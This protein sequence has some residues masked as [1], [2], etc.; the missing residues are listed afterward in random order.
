MLLIM[1]IYTILSG[2]YP[3]IWVLVPSLIIKNASLWS[4][5]Q[6]SMVIMVVGLLA[7]ICGFMTSF[8]KGNYRM[9][10]NN[11][12][13]YLIRD[14]M[15]SSLTMPYEETLHPDTLDRINFANESVQNPATGAGGII[16]TLLQLFG[17]IFAVVGFVGVLSTLS[18]WIMLIIFALIVFTFLL[19]EKTAQAEENFWDEASPSMRQTETM[20]DVARDPIRKKDILL[21]DTYGVLQ[22]YIHGFSTSVTQLY[23]AVLSRTFNAET[24]IA[25]LNLIRD[26]VLYSW[27]I[28]KFVNHQMDTSSFYLYSAGLT[29]FIAVAQQCMKDLS[30]IRKESKRF[31]CYIELTGNSKQPIQQE[32]SLTSS[33]TVSKMDLQKGVE[34]QFSEVNFPFL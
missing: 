21:Y 9:R 27:L 20:M 18:H 28:Y 1:A 14:L 25:L 5:T 34:V 8:L 3:F 2:I 29:S 19:S 26:A 23:K 11:V 32:V 7:M 6:I 13:Y 17:E 33:G 10:M 15:A 22:Q 4:T 31:L 24:G 30:L 16:L 12:R